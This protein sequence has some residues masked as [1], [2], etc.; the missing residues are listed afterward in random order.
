MFHRMRTSEKK[1]KNIDIQ[2]SIY[3]TSRSKALIK[4]FPFYFELK[5]KNN[6]EDI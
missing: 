4:L 1:F 3:G 2:L 6:N 5:P